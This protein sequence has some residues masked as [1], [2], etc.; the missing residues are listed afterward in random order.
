[1]ICSIL[2]YFSLF[3]EF[4]QA[5]G[6]RNI[7]PTAVVEA[8]YPLQTGIVAECNRY[9]RVRENDNC[10]SIAKAYAIT[11]DDFYRWNPAVGS[12]CETLWLGYHVCVGATKASPPSTPP[13]NP[14][15]PTGAAPAPTQSGMTSACVQ[16]YQ[17]QPADTCISI[18]TQKHPKISLTQFL[19][20]NPGVG[21]S[22]ES[23]LAGYYYCVAISSS[24]PKPEDGNGT[25]A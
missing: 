23:L 5:A 18:V 7:A 16:Y 9:H 20:W 22:C 17:A 25:R 10:A 14:G 8:P 19:D 15:T 24:Q 3:L 1:M 13:T 6:I 4:T 11:L 21:A 2:L 12:A